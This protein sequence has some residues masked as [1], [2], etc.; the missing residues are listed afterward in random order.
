[1]R[2]AF[3]AIRSVGVTPA[4]AFAPTAFKGVRRASLLQIIV[5]GFGKVAR[6]PVAGIFA[7][8]ARKT[9]FLVAGGSPVGTP[10]IVCTRP[11]IPLIGFAAET[12]YALKS[13][14]IIARK[15]RW[16]GFAGAV[17]PVFIAGCITPV[18]T[19]WPA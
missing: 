4:R 16:T 15:T 18:K 14:L 12:A 2:C 5:W 6:A 13:W 1:M 10:L 17:K 8:L 19:G 9:G 7:L 11:V 3:R